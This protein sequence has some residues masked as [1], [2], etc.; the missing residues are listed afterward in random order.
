MI[1]YL[2]RGEIAELLGVSL[3]TV[4]GY[5]KRGY[6]PEPDA[7]VGR[8]CGWLEATITDWHANRPGAGARTDL[9]TGRTHA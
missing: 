1:I 6:L 5:D 8:N 7:R 3:T 4:K 2:S 9:D